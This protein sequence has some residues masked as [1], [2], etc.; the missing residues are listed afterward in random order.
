MKL[1]KKIKRRLKKIKRIFLEKVYIHRRTLTLEKICKICKIELPKELKKYKN[2]NIKNITLSVNDL[3]PGCVLFCVERYLLK[4][5]HIENIK[6]NCFCVI[7]PKPIEGCQNIVVKDIKSVSLKMFRYIRNLCNAKVIAVTGSVGKTSTKEMIEAVLKE[8]YGDCITASIGNSNSRFKVA[9]NITRLNYNDK[10]YLQEVGAGS[11]AY[12]LVKFSAIMLNTD[13]A[14]YTNIKDSHIEWY[15]SR[16]NIAKEKFTLS[17]Y[18]NKN[19]LALINYDDEILRNHRFEQKRVSYA[20]TNPKADYYAKD[21]KIT[22]EGTKFKIIDSNENKEISVELKV[23]GEHHILNALS[24]YAIGKYLG[25]KQKTII[26]GIKKYQTSGNRQNLIDIGKY[27]VLADCY[28]SSYDAMKSILQTVD[29]IETKNNGKKIAVIGDIFELG[30][31]SEEIHRKIGSLLANANLDKVI[32]QGNETKYSYEEYK[33]IKNNAIYCKTRSEMFDVVNKTI[34]EDDLILFKASHGMHFSSAIDTLFGTDIGEISALGHKEYL[35]KKDNKFLYHVFNDHVTI[36]EYFGNENKI[37]IPNEFSS[38][39]VEKLG[40]VV[41]KGNKSIEEII[42]PNNITR[43]RGYCFKDSSLKRITFNK[44]L[45]QIG[46]GTFHLCSKLEKIV[47]PDGLLVIEYKAFAN[48][49]NLKEIYIP[50]STQK[51]STKAF[52]DT[53]NVIINCEKDSFAEQYAIKQGITYKIM[54]TKGDK[55][56]N[57]QKTKSK[58][59]KE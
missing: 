31:V 24:A 12:D 2:Q 7:T 15:G 29:M 20:L 6:K 34:N 19:G 53:N 38:L 52:L 3:K 45:K 33:K 54:K 25:I 51:I 10:I 40:K 17:D 48:C 47:L 8:K 22:S 55:N 57:N 13:I 14:V 36:K 59:S 42:L 11:G 43:L 18:G 56:D 5:R 30:K 41:F 32:F 9:Y 39:P 23:I 16:E 58:N 26:A 46:P 21:I 35:V 28:N 37:V 1:L 27:K 49:K 4:N 44:N 50:K